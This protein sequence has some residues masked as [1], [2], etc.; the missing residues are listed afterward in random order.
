M[1]FDLFG[2]N[3]TTVTQQL[4][5]ATQRYVDMMRQQAQGYQSGNYQ[6]PGNVQGAL[7]QYGR[8]AQ[9]GNLGLSA[10]TGDPSAVSS[11]MNPYMSQ[12]N[13]FFAQQRDRAVEAA[14]QRAT[15]AGAFGGARSDIGA[16]EAGNLADQTAAGYRVNEFNNAMARAQGLAQMGFGAAGAQAFLPQQYASGQLG[17]LGQGMGPYGMTTTQSTSTSPFQQLLGLG[18]TAGSF[19]LPPAGAAAAANQGW[20]ETDW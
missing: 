11:F 10:L 3:K 8:Y 18:L 12:L 17:L 2:S 14:N 4:D 19:F 15:L 7:D 16:A 6:L 20:S 13:P 9:G 5:P 1:G